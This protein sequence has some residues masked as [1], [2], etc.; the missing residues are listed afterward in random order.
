VKFVFDLEDMTQ[1][2]MYVRDQEG[3]NTVHLKNDWIYKMYSGLIQMENH[4]NEKF[5]K[6]KIT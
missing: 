5:T 6:N 4:Y 2:W 3:E 1:H